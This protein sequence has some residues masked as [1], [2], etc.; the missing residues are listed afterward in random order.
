MD[1]DLREG[2]AGG[3]F[4]SDSAGVNLQVFFPTTSSYNFYC[5]IHSNSG[6]YFVPNQLVQ[7][8]FQVQV[9]SPNPY[10]CYKLLTF[11]VVS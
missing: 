8:T 2:I 11:C 6:N 4:Y 7:L 1:V 5:I 3:L 10:V 9:V